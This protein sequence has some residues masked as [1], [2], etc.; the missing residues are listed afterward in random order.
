MENKHV[1]YALKDNFGRTSLHYAAKIG[2]NS[3]QYFLLSK[4]V[5]PNEPDIDEYSP[6]SYAL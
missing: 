1:P 4:K 5:N 2:F 3:L 6:Y